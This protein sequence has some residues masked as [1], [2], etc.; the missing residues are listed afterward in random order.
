MVPSEVIRPIFP[1]ASVNHSAPSGPAVIAEGRLAGVGK[2]NSVNVWAV[3]GIAA[4]NR[5]AIASTNGAIAILMAHFQLCP[6]RSRS[7]RAFRGV[8]LRRVTLPGLLPT[9]P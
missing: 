2:V 4:P 1:A 6:A 5:S 8:P 9:D 7:S 3:A